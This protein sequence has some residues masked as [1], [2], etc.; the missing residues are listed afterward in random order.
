MGRDFWPTLYILSLYFQPQ[1][2]RPHPRLPDLL[3]VRPSP[4]PGHTEVRVQVRIWQPRQGH[5]DNGDILRA[6][7]EAGPLHVKTLPVVLLPGIVLCPTDQIADSYNIF[8]NCT[9]VVNWFANLPV[10]FKR[11]V[12]PIFG[13]WGTVKSAYNEHL[14][15]E[16][17]SSVYP[18]FQ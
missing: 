10:R 2:R 18:D 3:Q 16:P 8:Y 7:P 15:V 4:A 9:L 1:R 17:I 11:P 14:S 12:T 6:L 13:Q 5:Q